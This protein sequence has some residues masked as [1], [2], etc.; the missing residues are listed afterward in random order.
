MAMVGGSGGGGG[1]GFDDDNDDLDS[2]SSSSIHFIQ[3]L[4]TVMGF[5]L[6]GKEIST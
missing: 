1:G 3:S 6:K 5:Q 2:S 4:M